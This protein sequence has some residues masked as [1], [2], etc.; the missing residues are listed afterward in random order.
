M[1]ISR[2]PWHRRITAIAAIGGFAV[3][4]ANAIVRWAQAVPLGHDEARYALDARDFLAGGAPRFLYSA[5]GMT[6]VPVP[7]LVAG[8]G[9][10]ALRLLPLV[11]GV[12]FLAC[13]WRLARKTLGAP[14]AAWTVA[15]LAGSPQLSQHSSELLSDL[16]STALLLLAISVLVTEAARPEG[17]RWRLVWIA[18]LL[19]AAFWIRFGS[20]P[21]IAIIGGVFLVAGW[22]AWRVRPWPVCLAVVLAALLVLP[23]FYRSWQ[24]TGSPLGILEMSREIPGEAHGLAGYLR[25]PL[26][27]YG[28]SI[29]VAMLAGLVPIRAVSARGRDRT[30]LALL[31]IAVAQIVVLAY[32]TQAQ[33]RFIYLATVLLVMLGV[34]TLRA[35]GERVGH[36]ARLPASV[37]ALLAVAF[38][39]VNAFEN[40]VGDYAASR[41]EKYSVTFIASAVIKA[42]HAA[43]QPCD[44]VAPD[45]RTRIEWYSGC[46][47]IMYAADSEGR[48]YLVGD[49]LGQTPLPEGGRWLAI[50]PGVVDVVRVR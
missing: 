26:S 9:E 28:A 50:V 15:L 12:V 1:S 37:V 31:A 48:L 49:G 16:P 40:A 32:T 10:R 21:A 13:V 5:P 3:W 44:V 46:R 34:D 42:D 11:L 41:I 19:A 7:G 33:P 30:R 25:S 43:S 45:D 22:R 27:H 35:C 39:W 38:M 20:A 18:P 47:A 14:T 36:T 6:L 29:G 24:L 17:P 2:D 4:I 23:H 8:G